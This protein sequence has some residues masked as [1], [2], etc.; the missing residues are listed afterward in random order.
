MKVVAKSDENAGD[1]PISRR[2]LLRRRADGGRGF[3]CSGIMKYYL[4]TRAQE[5]ANR[6]SILW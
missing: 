4:V 6:Y 1:K 5:D 3:I 2:D